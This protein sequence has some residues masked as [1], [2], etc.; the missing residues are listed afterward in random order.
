MNEITQFS[1]I[2]PQNI[3]DELM[4]KIENGEIDP[5]KIALSLKVVNDVL[6]LLKSNPQY[7]Q[8]IENELL[9]YGKNET[10]Q[11]FK[12]EIQHKK[13]VDYSTCNDPYLLR[14]EHEIKQRKAFL[15]SLQCPTSDEKSEGEF[16]SVPKTKISKYIK[17]SK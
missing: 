14:L 17:I 2:S 8:S 7:V 13:T 11:G 5:L 6:D 12:I 4:H 9:K 15:K 3:A 16:L 10:V 1:G